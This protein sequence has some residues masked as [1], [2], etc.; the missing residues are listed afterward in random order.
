MDGRGLCK[1][2]RDPCAVHPGDPGPGSR[3][4]RIEPVLIA[5]QAAHAHPAGEP[6]P[7]RARHVYG[8]DAGALPCNRGT[9]GTGN[10]G[11]SSGYGL[12]A[13]V[14]GYEPGVRAA[15]TR[16]VELHAASQGRLPVPLLACHADQPVRCQGVAGCKVIPGSGS[17]SGG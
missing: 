17:F 2:R 13:S 14:R 5:E 16:M 9:T 15:R 10:F 7:D 12:C 1:G 6:V 4:S 3:S 8:T 11:E